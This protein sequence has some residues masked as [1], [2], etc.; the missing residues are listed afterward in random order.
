M[1]K[2][3]YFYI[4]SSIH[5]AFAITCLV[6]FSNKISLNYHYMTFFGT[7]FCYNLL[8]YAHLFFQKK[9]KPILNWIFFLSMI[10]FFFGIYFYLKQDKWIQ[11]Q[12]M[13]IL[14]LVLI[15][16]FFRKIKC[17][18][19]FYVSF[20]ITLVTF[21]IPN[22]LSEINFYNIFARFL[23]LLALMIPFEII[24]YNQDKG[25]LATIPIVFGIVKTKQTGY[26]FLILSFFLIVSH[27][28]SDIN[29]LIYLLIYFLVFLSIYKSS[30]QKSRFYSL[31]WV[32]SIPILWFLIHIFV[33]K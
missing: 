14:F 29:K 20:V 23:F 26:F 33:F 31:F 16:P 12:L 18:K 8:K 13:I 9:R 25:K 32:E 15:Y 2:L 28:K 22:H 30:T 3:F 5:V 1:R 21:I 11:F 7:I 17:L 10:S 4:N 27:S 24:D 6:P 19:I